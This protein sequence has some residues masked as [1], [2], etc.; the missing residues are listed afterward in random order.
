MMD[1]T[2]SA[3]PEL[4]KNTGM[5]KPPPTA[6]S[7]SSNPLAC[8]VA[9]SP[10]RRAPQHHAREEGAQCGLDPELLGDEQ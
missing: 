5:K 7:F 3:M 1:C 9:A 6:S 10:T 4:T 8:P 2:S